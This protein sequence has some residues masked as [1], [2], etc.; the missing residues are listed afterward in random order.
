M[1][2]REYMHIHGRLFPTVILILLWL[3]SG[4]VH[5]PHVTKPIW[6]ELEMPVRKR[7]INYSAKP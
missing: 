6:A 4:Q 1:W 3:E 5:Y 2:G 7:D